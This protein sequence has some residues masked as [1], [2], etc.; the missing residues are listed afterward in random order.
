MSTLTSDLGSATA[1]SSWLELEPEEFQTHFSQ[2]PFVI[3]HH[4]CNHHL[5]N[6]ER[7]LKLSQTLPEHCI[8]YNAGEL[9][10]SMGA[11]QSPRNGLSVDET[12]RRIA[13]CKS[14][15]VLKYVENDPEY[16]EL[17][18]Q[19]IRQVQQHSEA[20]APGA[21]NFQGF[22][23]V[24]SPRSIT[25]YHTDPEHNFLLQIR[26]PKRIYMFDG[27]DRS[28]L[29][30]EE[31]ESF[32]ALRTRNLQFREEYRPKAWTFDL[33]PGD[34]LHFPVTYPHWVEN[35]DEVSISFSITFRTPDLDRRRA[36]YSF[37][38]G[39]RRRG[40]HPHPV[41]RTPWLD[42]MKYQTVRLARKFQNLVSRSNND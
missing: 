4:L 8:E 11:T 2:T 33:Q 30:E 5:F 34:G 12:I 14:W 1:R 16:R 24:T 15:L 20:I 36:V 42:S 37:N 18:H 7:L 41:G 25:P 19:C 35:Q 31:L 28:V 6:L 27:R 40:F 32:Y 3:K 21:R 38:A 13:E 26:G 9:P 22:I 39:L 17:L 29:S 23:F 10:I